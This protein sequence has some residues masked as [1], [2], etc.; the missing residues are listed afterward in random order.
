[1]L[2]SLKIVSISREKRFIH[3]SPRSILSS[4]R[5][6]IRPPRTLH[7]LQPFAFFHRNRFKKRK[8][9]NR[10]SVYPSLIVSRDTRNLRKS[11]IERKTWQIRISAERRN[12]SNFRTIRGEYYGCFRRR[13]EPFQPGMEV[14][15]MIIIA[16][17]RFSLNCLPT[18]ILS[19]SL[20]LPIF[21]S[22]KRQAFISTPDHLGEYG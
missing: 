4:F 5:F 20:S 12:S 7:R 15:G 16:N 9:N 2:T 6:I 18:I 11:K 17:E 22:V 19:L 1:M 10:F 21:L 14:G 8:K 3:P 13:L